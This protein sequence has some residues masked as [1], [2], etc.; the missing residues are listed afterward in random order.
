M[1]LQTSSLPNNT[2]NNNNNHNNNN[3]NNNNDHHHHCRRCRDR[4]GKPNTKALEVDQLFPLVIKYGQTIDT[5]LKTAGISLRR[6]ISGYSYLGH[7]GN[8][9]VRSIMGF[10]IIH[11]VIHKW[12]LHVIIIIESTTNL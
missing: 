9:D 4:F 11:N 2:N 8:K 1:N 10:I 7:Q 12:K 3:N 6:K 5:Q